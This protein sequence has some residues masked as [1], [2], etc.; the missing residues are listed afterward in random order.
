M[1]LVGAVMMVGTLLV[2]N[3]FDDPLRASSFAVTVMAI[4]QWFNAWN[5]RS[6]TQSVFTMPFF[7]NPALLIATGIVVA[8]QLA[9]LHLPILQKILET[10]PLS[11]SEWLILV[12]IGFSIILADEVRKSIIRLRSN[13]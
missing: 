11:L 8:L 7:N 5:V 4:F 3:Y 13:Q 12:V 6:A 1:I 2:V 9:S 10:Q